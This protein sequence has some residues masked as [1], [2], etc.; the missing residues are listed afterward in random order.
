M[1][2]RNRDGVSKFL[3]GMHMIN[4]SQLNIV[5]ANSKIDIN[6][7]RNP[8][9]AQPAEFGGLK[10]KVFSV[11]NPSHSL[12]LVFSTPREE[13]ANTASILRN[14]LEGKC[15]NLWAKFV[16]AT[17]PPVA[18]EASPISTF[19]P[20]PSDEVTEGTSKTPRCPVTQAIIIV[21]FVTRASTKNGADSETRGFVLS[22]KIPRY[23]T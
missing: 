3:F 19:L 16:A 8:F 7:S 23:T 9:S 2:A 18:L 10:N 15:S 17:N 22:I 4:F 13:M 21:F 6:D 14:E 12:V 5:S 11:I 1:K 20:S